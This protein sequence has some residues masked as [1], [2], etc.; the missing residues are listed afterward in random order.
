MPYNPHPPPTP[1]QSKGK[2]PAPG[3]VPTGDPQQ[4]ANIDRQVQTSGALTSNQLSYLAQEM[5]LQKQRLGLSRQGLGLDRS[6]IL[7]QL[8]LLG[9]EHT[10]A[11]QRFGLETGQAKRTAGRERQDF[12]G[13]EGAAGAITT[14]GARRGFS[15]ITNQLQ[16][17]LKDI[18]FSKADEAARYKEQG[19]VLHNALAKLGLQ[20]KDI[21]IAGK[22]LD[23]RKSKESEAIAL[24]GIMD[25]LGIDLTGLLG[26]AQTNQANTFAASGGTGGNV[27]AQGGA[28]AGGF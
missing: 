12:S 26:A 17:R 7:A 25:V 9:T 10:I 27:Y 4:A 18:G 5:N 11:G 19:T 21:G 1:Q 22:E 16:T 14:P 8:G 20:A 24:Q 13:A 3:L 15:D 23:L 28:S 6:N 2:A